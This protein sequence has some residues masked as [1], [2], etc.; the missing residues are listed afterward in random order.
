MNR[1]IWILFLLPALFLSCEIS[2][3]T[4]GKDPALSGFSITSYSFRSYSETVYLGDDIY[5]SVT[6][7]DPDDD[8]ESLDVT[9]YD[10]AGNTAYSDTIESTFIHEGTAWEFVIDGAALAAGSYTLELQAVDTEGNESNLINA[11][12][13]IVTNPKGSVTAGDITVTVDSWAALGT[14]STLLEISYHVTSTAAVAIDQV[15]VS[16]D[17]LDA[18][19]TSIGTTTGTLNNVGATASSTAVANV[20]DVAVANSIPTTHTITFY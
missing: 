16:F 20:T 9:V 8:P 11:A 1:C 15:T 12:F 2:D 14:S 13:S 10:A 17:V 4:A 19:M 5:I 7:D 3:S 18:G 6:V